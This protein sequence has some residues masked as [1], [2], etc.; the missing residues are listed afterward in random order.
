MTNQADYNRAATSASQRLHGRLDELVR[1][2][3]HGYL[4]RELAN[5]DS[6]I[7]R[8]YAFTGGKA[9]AVGQIRDSMA[10]PKLKLYSFE[11]FANWLAFVEANSPED[12]I[13][14]G[15]VYAWS[16]VE[17]RD[18]VVAKHTEQPIRPEDIAVTAVLVAPGVLG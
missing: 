17:A 2:A 8:D 1:S 4:T 15:Y 6:P 11:F 18:F 13:V 9:V 14:S 5:F 3:I 16:E 12:C 7:T 10:R